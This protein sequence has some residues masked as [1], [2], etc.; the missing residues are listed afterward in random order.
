MTETT[1]TKAPDIKVQAPPEDQQIALIR[2]NVL[3]REL[4]QTYGRLK[5][6]K[7]LKVAQ[8][9]LFFMSIVE[10]SEKLRV[11]TSVSLFNAFIQAGS[12]GL[13]FNPQLAHCYLIP[14]RQRK[15][16]N[17]ERW[18]DYNK[19]VPIIAYA[20]PGYRGLLHLAIL[21]GAIKWGRAEVVH[22]RDY[23]RYLGPTTKP[24]F[25]EGGQ[26]AANSLVV[27]RGARVG[28]YCHAQTI[29]GSDLAGRMTWD[30]VEV[31]RQCSEAP[32][33]L[34]WRKFPGEGGKKALIRREQKTWPKIANA[35]L[36]QRAIAALNEH[37]GIDFDKVING[38][39]EV[40]DTISD[41]QMT[42]LHAKCTDAGMKDDQADVKLRRL[43]AT[44]GYA[45][46]EDVSAD[47]VDEVNKRL[48]DNLQEIKRTKDSR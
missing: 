35:E 38:K 17:E 45:K 6:V 28:V 46:V 15:K 40:V 10:A 25:V 5:A 27:P 20:S 14:R 23:F 31:I 4:S 36:F 33:S 32:K 43:V 13:S 41:E 29:D 47:Q 42:A 1:Q 37:E 12:M 39:S 44:F 19:R 18:D 48:D 30:E 16:E 8:E 26:G 2:E 22:E 11:S 24:E 9:K 34:M 21:G 3:T 7:D